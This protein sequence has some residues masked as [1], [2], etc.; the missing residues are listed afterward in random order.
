MNKIKKHIENSGG[1]K[2]FMAGKFR[3]LTEAKKDEKPL[4]KPE[5][6]SIK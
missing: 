6:F 1:F 3:E 2:K 4:M 5:D